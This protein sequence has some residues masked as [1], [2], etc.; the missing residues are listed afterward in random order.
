M[1]THSYSWAGV[2]LRYLK[3][4]RNLCQQLLPGTRLRLQSVSRTDDRY[5]FV[6]S[7]P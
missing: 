5:G 6:N 1:G 3:E 4:F 2:E 7:F